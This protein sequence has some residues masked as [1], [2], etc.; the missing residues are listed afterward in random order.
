M[1]VSALQS[2]SELLSADHRDSLFVLGP[3]PAVLEVQFAKWLGGL[4]VL[5]NEFG[6]DE[7]CRELLPRGGF[8]RGERGWVSR[9]IRGLDWLV[10]LDSDDF[11]EEPVR[12][13]VGGAQAGLAVPDFGLA[14]DHILLSILMIAHD[15][16]NT[17]GYCPI[18]N[19]H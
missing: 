3:H 5:G 7:G 13:G 19:T 9:G 16:Y 8:G 4:Q 10:V 12:E 1:E 17:I 2:L 6:G 14:P 15:K 18:L 11:F